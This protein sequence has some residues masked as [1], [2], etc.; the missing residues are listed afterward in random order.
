MPA[1]PETRKAAS[2]ALIS[3]FGRHLQWGLALVVACGLTS[4]A[5]FSGPAL[6]DFAT[7]VPMPVKGNLPFV[8]VQIG[9]K[10]ARFLV[11]SGASDC[12]ISPEMARSMGLYV[13]REKAMVKTAAGDRVP[14]PMTILP[15]LAIGQAEF[16]RVPAF[17]YDFGKLRGMVG[18]MDGVVGYS[19]F[20][21]ATLTLD[22]TRGQLTI[23]PGPLLRPG[24]PG[25]IP[26]KSESGVPRVPVTGGPRPIWVDVDSGSTGGLEIDPV[27]EGLTTLGPTRPGGLSKSI[28]KTYRTG[29]ARVVGSL[30]LGDVEMAD[31]IVE[32][33]TGDYRVGGEVLQNTM[34]SFDQTSSLAQ[35]TFGKS[36]SFGLEP[37]RK[38]ISPSRIGTGIGFDSRWIVQDVVPGSPA[39][40]AGVR[41]GDRC[42]QVQGVPVENFHDDYHSLLQTNQAIA[43][44][45]QRGAKSFSVKVPVVLQVQ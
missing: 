27:R 28:G 42:I 41:M 25:I 26:L 13:S 8:S 15:S 12:V 6:S 35:V 3:R 5:K 45:F 1:S 31:P 39:Q 16:K 33:T 40:K 29:M 37:R 44:T 20:R 10:T 14:I 17:V 11:D 43:Y 22:Y 2:L 4:C 21:D 24:Q 34:I 23:T 18:A 7:Q 19:L 9:G 38:L 32:V 30:Y 36:K